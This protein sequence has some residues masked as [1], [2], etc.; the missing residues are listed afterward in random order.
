M[1]LILQIELNKLGRRELLVFHAG[2]YLTD[3]QLTAELLRRGETD[4]KVLATV[5]A[6][7]TPTLREQVAA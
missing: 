6:N 7:R 1:K 5:R 3:E 4:W 2:H